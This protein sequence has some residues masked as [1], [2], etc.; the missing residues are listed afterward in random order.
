M[1]LL[2]HLSGENLDLAREEILALA[3]AKKYEQ[4]KN[5]LIVTSKYS[6]LFER[7][8]YTHGIYEVLFVSR[9]KDFM[10]DIL[11]FNFNKHYKKDFK[12]KEEKGE[13]SWGDSVKKTYYKL[14][15]KAKPRMDPKV[16]D[17][18]EQKF[19]K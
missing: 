4:H 9:A 6:A 19:Q 1:E 5:V 12:V 2:F 10:T 11:H 15:P 17:F 7:L 13:Y 14:G 18:F 8:A 3:D 16:Q